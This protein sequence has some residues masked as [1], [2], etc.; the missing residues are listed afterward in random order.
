[1]TAQT[2]RLSTALAGR[3]RIERHLGEGGMASVYLAEDLKHDR[4]VALKLLKPELAPVLGA[5]H[6][7]A[8]RAHDDQVVRCTPRTVG[9]SSGGGPTTASFRP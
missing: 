4:E 7:L 5:A 1:M 6:E 3:Y 9:I 8:A 2:D